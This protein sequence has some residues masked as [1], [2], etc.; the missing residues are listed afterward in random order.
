MNLKHI[1]ADFRKVEVEDNIFFWRSVFSDAIRTLGLSMTYDDLQKDG[2]N[3]GSRGYI[4]MHNGSITFSHDPIEKRVVIVIHSWGD[5]NPDKLIN[6]IYDLL[7]PKFKESTI[8]R[9]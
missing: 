9:F 5:M 2:P 1:V 8:T 3:N 4:V 7:E 6:F